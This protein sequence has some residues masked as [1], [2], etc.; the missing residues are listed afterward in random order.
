VP[1]VPPAPASASDA[2]PDFIDDRIDR[3]LD[4]V[5]R[6]H[7]AYLDFVQTNVI[8]PIRDAGPDIA[9][10]LAD[11]RDVR[12]DARA[13]SP[14][15]SKTDRMRSTTD[16]LAAPLD[17]PPRIAGPEMPSSEDLASGNGP[18]TAKPESSEPEDPAPGDTAAARTDPGTELQR[19]RARV[20]E[21]VVAPLHDLLDA[22]DV[23]GALHHGRSE[24]QAH[25]TEMLADVPDVITRAEPAGLYASTETDSP[26]NRLGKAVVRGMRQLRA[27]IGRGTPR[28]QD[29]PLARLLRHHLHDRLP[30]R[31]EPALRALEQ[32]LAHWVAEVE[33]A[34]IQWT[35]AALRA[36]AAYDRVD[37]VDLAIAWDAAA[38]AG[39]LSTSTAEGAGQSTPD[40]DPESDAPDE[41]RTG[42]E[43][44]E[45]ETGET[46]EIAAT[47]ARAEEREAALDHAR[48]CKEA[49]QEAEAT[50]HTTLTSTDA[51]SLDETR[52]KLQEIRSRTREALTLDARE[53]GT[54]MARHHPEPSV[55][56]TPADGRW[57]AWYR[58]ANNRLAIALHLSAI[59]DVIWTEQE[60]LAD[61]IVEAGIVP[62][63]AIVA[64]GVRRLR[65][66]HAEI[67]AL[68]TFPDDGAERR[69][70]TD[71]ERMLDRALDTLESDLVGALRQTTVR[72]DTEAVVETHVMAIVDAIDAQPDAFE[73]H[74]LP[75]DPE[76]AIDPDASAQ[77]VQWRTIVHETTEVLLF[78]AWRAILPPVAEATTSATNAAIDVVGIVRF[79]L[80]AAVEEL[81]DLATVRRQ[82]TTGVEN[83]R[84]HLDAAR[85]LGLD[86]LDRAAAAL[87]A[88]DE[89]L[90][91]ASEPVTRAVH[92]TTAEA[93]TRV[94]DRTQAAGRAR[95]QVLRVQALGETFLRTAS[96]WGQDTSRE[97]QI[98]LR[99][100]LQLGQ[101]RAAK[102][103][104]MGQTAVGAG[105]V[106]ENV[107]REAVTA[108]VTLDDELR[109]MPLV[110]RRLFSLRPVRDPDLLVGRD[111]DLRRVEQHI[112]QWKQGLPNA[113]ILTADP[114]S[115]LTSFVNVLAATTLRRARRHVVSLDRR[116]STEAEVAALFAA[117]LGLTHAAPPATLNELADRIQQSSGSQRLRV[118]TVERLEHLFLRSIGGTAL[119][120]RVLEFMSATDVH[121]LW[122]GTMSGFG[123]QIL[124]AHEPD[125]ADLVVRHELSAFG[126]ETIEELIVRRHRRSGLSLTFTTPDAS[127]QPLLAR[128]LN[129]AESD[130]ERQQILRE[131]Y[132]D[133][134]HALCGQNVMLALFYWFRSVHLTEDG[135]GVAVA[136]VSPIRFDFLD[137]FSLQRSFAL[138]A[139]L[140][141]A[142]LTVDELAEVLQISSAASRTL[143]EALGNAQLIT[144][145]ETV[146]PP[147]TDVFDG[148]VPGT[149][150]RVRPM[151]LHPVARHL[152]SRNIVH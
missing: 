105:A 104:Q 75:S 117:A 149:R 4:A 17:L 35:H 107:L 5:T 41:P 139:L 58:Q 34:V 90:H 57:S 84:S 53:A 80:G 56:E 78:D 7:E 101:R 67:D 21:A 118:A 110:Y 77:T 51:L 2:P 135:T 14:S 55:P 143:L 46:D 66:L 50:F 142:T 70:A 92:S 15:R 11:A 86:G 102:I 94:H 10:A 85:E 126:R 23:G 151:V 25:Q 68:L 116:L 8:D 95:E 60:T 96:D 144:P 38:E 45:T 62:S 120:A 124:R 31:E 20:M 63:R 103:V 152:R 40:A 79:N 33:R 89:P 129:R 137:E 32:R 18:E 26:H 6:Q 115:G 83:A 109:D 147:G 123:W 27:L 98:R 13:A 81:Q 16:V 114:G 36:E 100:A 28:Q 59:R 138:K 150:Y 22:I 122:I 91:R 146:G 99:R 1:D 44:G 19:Y 113:L 136:P 71:L 24:L 74:P 87:T 97:L 9:S 119:L 42:T 49:M 131:E 134:L 37:V 52:S 133:R 130:E 64:D 29:V 125:A 108:V 47:H 30:R 76:E 112:Q 106:D 93:W 141:H 69:L 3:V 145:A 140:E 54:F 65:E 43:T 111:A 73:V 148:V 128:R 48:R 72:N 12:L 132:F 39:P 61:D 82:S 88:A 127:S 121:I